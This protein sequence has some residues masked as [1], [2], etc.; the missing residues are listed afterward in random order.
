VEPVAAD[1]VPI[2]EVARQGVAACAIGH[3]VVEGGVEHGH[4]WHVGIVLAGHLDAPGACRVVQGRERDERLQLGEHGVVHEDGAGE[5]VA[6]VHDPVSDGE[7]RVG[8]VSELGEQQPEA[9]GVVG[10][11]AL[12]DAWPAVRGVVDQAGAVLADPLDEAGG[13][14]PLVPVQAVLDGG[15]SGVKHEDRRHELSSFGAARRRA[16]VQPRRR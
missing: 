4:L 10:D 14:R 12:D 13:E 1:P 8:R 3:G 16:S 5:P 11:R 6:A 2:C 7:Q 15:R 9:L